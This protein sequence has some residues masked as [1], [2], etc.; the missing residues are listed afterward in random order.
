MSVLK[1][2]CEQLVR[3]F[4]ELQT[5]FPEERDIKMAVDAIDNGRKINPRLVL[6]LFYEH[7][8][9]DYASSIY[10]K[11][12]PT[13]IEGVD[14]KIKTQFNDMMVALTIFNKHWYTMGPTN[15]EVIIQYLIVLCKLCEKARA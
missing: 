11:D 8:Y 5:T 1:A 9:K 10:A 14:K 7:V 3:F 2:F 4:Q 13:I 12:V 6:D 15:Q